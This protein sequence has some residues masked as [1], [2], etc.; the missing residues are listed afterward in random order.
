MEAKN[1]SPR[2]L[3]DLADNVVTQ[4]LEQ[5]TDVASVNVTGGEQREIQVNIDRDRLNAYGITVAQV[6]SA[7][8]QANTNVSVGYIQTGPQYAD[9]RFLGE[10]ATVDEL[11]GLSLSFPASSSTTATAST[12]SATTTAASSSTTATAAAPV[13]SPGGN[14]IVINLGDIATVE[15]TSLSNKSQESTLNGQDAVAISVLKTS[16]GNTLRAVD[17]VKEEIN[18]VKKFLPPDVRFIVAHDQS[19]DVHNN[20]ND[21]LVSLFLGAVLAMLLVY[22]FLHNLRATT[23]VA[24]AIPTCVIA[25]FLPLSAF[26]MTLNTMSLLGLSLSIGVLIDDS[27][28][29]IENIVRHL[30]M[31]QEPREAALMGRMEIGTA[32]VT[33][34]MVDLVVFVPI[35]MMG[36][37]VGQFFQS[38]GVTVVVAVLC[39]L[40][41]SF[42]LTPM[43]A[44]RWFKK[45]EELEGGGN[46]SGFFAMFDRSYASFERGYRRVLRGV[47]KHPWPVVTIG[48]L[49]LVIAVIFLAPRLG[50]TFAPSQDQS[51]VQISVTAA[52]GASLSFTKTITD[53]IERR[54]HA[55]KSLN[56]E[57][58]YLL[59]EDGVSAAGG[60]ASGNTGTNYAVI[61]ASLYDKA[62]PIDK[63]E[64][65]H[66]EHLRNETDNDV[67]VKIRKVLNGIAGAR[68]TAAPTT[69]FGGG[70]APLEVDV[71]GNDFNQI[72]NGANQV[73]A[74]LNKVPG[75][76]GTDL[77]FKPSQ[78]EIELRLDRVRAAQ[79]GLNVQQVSEA[80]SYAI[81]GQ[82][83]SAVSRADY[84]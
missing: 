10:F 18:E 80:L 31:G 46:R 39:S 67:A 54:I 6:A 48:N 36:G 2:D 57:V 12:A 33:L 42:T 56:S 68:L 3:R 5:A 21:V 72:I 60:S 1:E 34:T 83:R 13:A 26:G 14:N 79:Y 73:M 51:L 69:G 28:V 84:R 44:S 29:V 16:D 45:G 23:I 4:R 77:S 50:F 19:V 63:V 25:T 20:V 66:H 17:G 40:A 24:I 30:Q 38:F 49:V 22:V 53:E 81:P 47:I 71:T 8:T 27:I 82:H 9:I 37:I 76:Y 58:K 32:A 15:D 78:P 43:L 35:A 7:I 62:A 61:Q 11:K 74:M 75:I 59:T 52:P 41:V 55:D 70:G 65:W 64:F